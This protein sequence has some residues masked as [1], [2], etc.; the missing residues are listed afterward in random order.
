[1]RGSIIALSWEFFRRGWFAFAIAMSTA[2][3]TAA[4]R[5][6]LPVPYGI[7][8]AQTIAEPDVQ[9][10]FMLVSVAG[11]VGSVLFATCDDRIGFSSRLYVFPR[12]TWSLISARLTLVT[13]TAA[14]LY[15]LP[16]AL[17]NVIFGTDFPLLTVAYF[18]MAVT[19]FGAAGIWQLADFRFLKNVALAGALVLLGMWSIARFR[20]PDPWQSFTP[21]QWLTLT[22]YLIGAYAVVY[23]N[24]VRD[25]QG[26][27]RDWPDADL[28]LSWLMQP[29]SRRSETLTSAKTAQFWFEW[30]ARGLAVPGVAVAIISFLFAL[31][32]LTNR[33]SAEML[34]DTYFIFLLVTPVLLSVVSSLMFGDRM[35]KKDEFDVF[36]AVRPLSDRDIGFA[37]FRAALLSSAASWLVCVVGTMAVT[38]IAVQ[39]GAGGQSTWQ[40]LSTWSMSEKIVRFDSFAALL[41]TSAITTWTVT[42]VSFSLLLSGRRRYAVAVMLIAEGLL[43]LYVTYHGANL[44]PKLSATAEHTAVN[45]VGL[46]LIA[47]TVFVFYSAVRRRF[48]R[49]MTMAICGFAAVLL[50]IPFSAFFLNAEMP[51][52]FFLYGVMSLAIIPIA[53][54]PLALA[55]NRHR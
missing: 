39:L 16:G 32:C 17:A 24:V 4:L 44:L 46:L 22:G 23:Y 51:G 37:I 55:A 25:R 47:L 31:V 45:V 20:E 27:F 13:L 48:I 15:V 43:F 14:A 18:L 29:F 1:M 42:G 38:G 36:V 54:V 11:I 35:P 6:L 28:W 5:V 52:S 30:R 7:S 10:L 9:Y 49:R 19:A 2:L 40:L 21:W 41:A 3:L 12:T 8:I 50:T 26:E 33:Q 53:T 34:H